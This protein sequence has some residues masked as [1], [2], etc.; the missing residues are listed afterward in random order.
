MQTLSDVIFDL[1][2]NDEFGWELEN[3]QE[4]RYNGQVINDKFLNFVVQKGD[5]VEIT[6]KDDKLYKQEI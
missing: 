2:V 3:I 5:V 4:M 1:D 6:T